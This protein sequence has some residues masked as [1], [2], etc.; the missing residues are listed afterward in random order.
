MSAKRAPRGEP[1]VSGALIAPEADLPA[2]FV[3]PSLA[4]I[5]ENSE[6]VLVDGA[7]R[8]IGA[9][10]FVR[11]PHA[12]DALRIPF[13]A[14]AIG[15]LSRYVG[16]KDVPK[17]ERDR[18]SCEECGKF[19]EFPAVHLDYVGHAEATER[20]LDVDPAWTWEPMGTDSDGLPLVVTRGD[21]SELWIR[22]TINGVSRLGVG[23]ASSSKADVAKELIGDAIRNAAMRFGVALD[24]WKRG[25]A[26]EER[27]SSSNGPVAVTRPCP[28]CGKQVSDNRAAHANDSKKPAWRCSNRACTGGSNGRSWASWDPENILDTWPEAVLG[29]R[30][31]NAMKARLAEAV[32]AERA[33]A[34]W[35]E[36][37]ELYSLA[38]SDPI[39]LMVAQEIDAELRER[40]PSPEVVDPAEV[41]APAPAEDVDS[42][43]PHPFQPV[44]GTTMCGI[45]A[46]AA[47][48]EI[49][50]PS[51][52]PS[53]GGDAPLASPSTDPVYAPGEEPFE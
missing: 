35:T 53:R 17:A 34:V 21:V 2:D 1:E 36:V 26:E 15:K 28:A 8:A 41:S 39:P 29:P 49:H 10:P 13:P 50:K 3:L 23:T 19:H 27:D 46:A 7:G 4:P 9:G 16:P 6:A 12:N 14:E 37:L 42:G 52:P 32:G 45:C 44:K 20:L 47:F 18:H 31:T 38:P 5:P 51:L 25:D 22:L 24:L 40:A 30:A 43:L 11:H 33:A 48:D